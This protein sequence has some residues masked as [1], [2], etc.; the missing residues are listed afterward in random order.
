MLSERN[1]FICG[2]LTVI[3]SLLDN[4]LKRKRSKQHSILLPFK[5]LSHGSHIDSLNWFGPPTSLK[6]N[7]G[8]KDFRQVAPQL[9]GVNSLSLTQSAFH[10]L[11][12]HLVPEVM[13]VCYSPYLKT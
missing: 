8:M 2:R 10:T 11:K 9:N 1:S 7:A 5:L 6:S 13:S 12:Y 3:S 4:S